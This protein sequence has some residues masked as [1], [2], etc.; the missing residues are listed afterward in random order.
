MAAERE[1]RPGLSLPLPAGVPL[2]RQHSFGDVCCVLTVVLVPFSCCD[3]SVGK[4]RQRFFPRRAYTWVGEKDSS[5]QKRKSMKICKVR[6]NIKQ[7]NNLGTETQ[8]A[9]GVV[10][11]S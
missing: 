5:R 10:M 2:Q 4:T 11:L 3:T 8:S 1:E 6:I 7:K 9:C